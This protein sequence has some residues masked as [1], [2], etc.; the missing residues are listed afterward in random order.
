MCI[1]DRTTTSTTSTTGPPP[2][3]FERLLVVGDSG[4]YFLGDPITAVA[5]DVTVVQRGQV[6]CGVLTV[7]GGVETAAGFLADAPE[8][9][10][11][12]TRLQSDVEA[13]Q[14]TDVLFVYSWPGNGAREID[15]ELVDPCQATFATEYERQLAA[16]AALAGSTGARTVVA[17]VAYFTAPD[18]S[19]A[20]AETTDC[21]NDSIERVVGA[22]NLL[23][24]SDWVCP[25]GECLLEMDGVTLRDDGLHFEGPGG[26]LAADWIVEQLRSRAS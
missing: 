18:G 6:G 10:S 9:A 17:D 16:L 19:V 5:D 23:P 11:F 4:A 2:P 15:G 21:L 22:D 25:G 14:P 26:L 13:F 12:P 24:L 8:C 20:F 1:R 3:G 7:G